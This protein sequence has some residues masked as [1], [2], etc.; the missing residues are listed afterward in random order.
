MSNPN[1][2]WTRY[3]RILAALIEPHPDPGEGWCVDCSLNGGRTVV[4]PADGLE[5]HTEL[6]GDERVMLSARWP[7]TSQD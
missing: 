7:R 3:R 4:L 1:S 6:H 5:E 2:L